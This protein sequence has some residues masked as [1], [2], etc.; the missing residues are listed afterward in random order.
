LLIFLDEMV[1]WLDR[2]ESHRFQIIYLTKEIFFCALMKSDIT[3]ITNEF[4]FC[5]IMYNFFIFLF[6]LDSSGKREIIFEFV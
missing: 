2:K 6:F 3:G 5:S 4:S 1:S